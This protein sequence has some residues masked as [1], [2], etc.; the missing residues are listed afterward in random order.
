M[1]VKDYLVG[2]LQRKSS[3]NAQRRENHYRLNL[4]IQLLID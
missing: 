1:Q 3:M 2:Y 4:N